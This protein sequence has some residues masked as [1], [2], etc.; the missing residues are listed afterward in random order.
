MASAPERALDL[1]C[2]RARSHR[3][4]TGIS[5]SDSW[6]VG[7]R[8]NLES[9][10]SVS[11]ISEP[12][13]SVVMG[14]FNADE[15]LSAAIESILAQE[16]VEFEFVIV[17][18]GSTDDSK[19]ILDSFSKSDSR[20][21]LIRQTN[22]GLT[23]SLVT[24][25]KAAQGKFVAR[26]DADDISLPGRLKTMANFLEANPNIG[27]ISCATERI[28][29]EGESVD[30]ITLS[31]TDDEICI[32]LRNEDYGVP[33]H[34]CMMFRKDVYEKAGGYRPQF[35]FAQDADLWSR[36]IEHCD[37]KYLQETL[38]QLRWHIGSIS[39]SK[40]HL[41]SEFR[42]LGQECRN[43]RRANLSESELLAEAADLC[44]VARQP[45]KDARVAASQSATARILGQTM[46]RN[47]NREGRKYIRKALALAPLNPRSWVALLRSLVGSK[48]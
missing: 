13:V 2:G 24:G 41:Q 25:C 31:G 44:V 45:K 28:A 22:S 42:R 17:D 33:C 10:R 15:Y 35:Y 14:V 4:S 19:S 27:F 1:G 48:D 46:L 20:I 32:R 47:G 23:R 3:L 12:L 6:K 9:S 36:L 37:Y 5:L 16:G 18:D 39:G 43:A 26:Q 11:E 29:T 34:G 7:S 40:A 21:R 38:Y 8:K 30:T